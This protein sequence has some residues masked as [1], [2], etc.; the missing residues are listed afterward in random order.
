MIPDDTLTWLLEPDEPS[1]RY[2]TLRDLLDRPEN[3]SEVAEAKRAIMM[4]GPVAA[5]LSR[6]NED[7]GFLTPAMVEQYGYEVAK[8]GYQ[9]KKNSI[10]QLLILAQLG[11]DRDD[12]RV[13]KLCEYVL[14]HNY[15]Q[16][17]KVIGINFMRKEGIDF[18]PLPCFVSN[19]VWSLSTLGYHDDGRVQD[20]IQWLLQY[21]R[22]DDGGFR[23][24]DEWPYRG[25]RDRCFGRHT[26]FSGVTRALKAMA[27][28]PEAR[29]TKETDVFI[30]K[31]TDFVLIHRLYR[32]NHGAWEPI[33]PEFELF[34]F[35]VIHFDD[36]IE[37]V[38]TLQGL[39]VRHEAV[40][41]GLQFILG[42]R[43]SDGRWKLG[44]TTSRSSTY[45]NFGQR[46]KPS[47]WITLRALKVLK[48]AGMVE[49]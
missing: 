45:A 39:G 23:T 10:W 31:A 38:D 9:P 49:I 12:P 43:K 33:R 36:V 40:D 28:V 11:V 27:T 7:G 42:K 16:D 24:P 41:E 14:D 4:S 15:N 13:K 25:R 3:D 29:R 21:Q 35:P 32:R 44:Y 20:S 19:M 2:F 17:R 30:A 22:F 34:T 46:G 48:N 8:T 37:I 26:C 6:Q 5:I 1:V 47:K 18:W